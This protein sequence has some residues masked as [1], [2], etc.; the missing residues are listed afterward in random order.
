MDLGT[1]NGTFLNGERI[2]S[3]RFYELLLKVCVVALYACLMSHDVSD[4]RVTKYGTLIKKLAL[5]QDVIKFG[6]S[7]REYLLLH[8]DAAP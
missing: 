6:M 5:L 8:E 4:V 1:T 7:S 3:E 2:E